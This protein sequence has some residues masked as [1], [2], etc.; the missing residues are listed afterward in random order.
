M[1]VWL[2]GC[3]DMCV[4]SGLQGCVCGQWAAE[5]CMCGQRGYRDIPMWSAGN[6]EAH[7]RLLGTPLF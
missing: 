1:P 7:L 6:R 2:V 3:R 5:M 4:V